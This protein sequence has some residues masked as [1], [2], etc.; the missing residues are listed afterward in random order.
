M[1]C[2]DNELHLHYDML[3]YIYK[4]RKYSR[5]CFDYTW[6]I[7]KDKEISRFTQNKTARELKM[8]FFMRIIPH[9]DEYEELSDEKRAY[10]S[11]ENFEID[12][13]DDDFLESIENNDAERGRDYDCWKSQKDYNTASP[14]QPNTLKLNLKQVFKKPTVADKQNIKI[15]IIDDDQSL[16]QIQNLCIR[17][18]NDHA[19]FQKALVTADDKA[20]ER[21]ELSIEEV[22]M[23]LAN[24]NCMSSIDD[25]CISYY[26]EHLKLT[27]VGKMLFDTDGNEEYIDENDENLNVNASETSMLSMQ[28]VAPSIESSRSEILQTSAIVPDFNVSSRSSSMITRSRSEVL[29]PSQLIN[30]S[31]ISS[32][33]RK[34]NIVLNPATNERMQKFG[35]K[36]RSRHN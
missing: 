18:V 14:N 28:D 22:K 17:E 20:N 33:R 34:R 8:E 19:E 1:H 3:N 16:T 7:L 25:E 6:Q 5:A 30:T 32:S 29:T 2:D 21:N 11:H 26:I 12:M 35:K 27:T 4:E 13:D 15:K 9:L 31:N 23:R 36:L 10:F 24:E